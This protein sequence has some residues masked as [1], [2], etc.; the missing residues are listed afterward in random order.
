MEYNED[1]LLN[2][3]DKGLSYK[4]IAL[5]LNT[6]RSRVAAKIRRMRL[7]NPNLVEVRK[8]GVHP[9]GKKFGKQKKELKPNKQTIVLRPD[10]F[11]DFTKSQLRQILKEAVENTR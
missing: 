4:E 5:E 8:W 7:K 1:N 10:G 9:Q 11:K 3:F 6:T 2:L